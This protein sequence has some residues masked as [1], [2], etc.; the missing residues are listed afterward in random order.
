MRTRGN[1]LLDAQSIL[2]TGLMTPAFLLQ[3]ETIRKERAHREKKTEGGKEAGKRNS[4]SATISS[5]LTYTILQS[6]KFC[7]AGKTKDRKKE[8][9]LNMPKYT[10]TDQGK[11]W[12]SVE[13]F[14]KK[15]QSE[16]IKIP[17]KDCC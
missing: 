2:G 6:F 9:T 1:N 11:R 10:N 15:S 14:F 4:N 3:R 13:F 7:S 16:F 12:A 17:R 5:N 8:S